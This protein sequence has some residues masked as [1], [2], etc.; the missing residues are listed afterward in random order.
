MNGTRLLIC[1][2]LLFGINVL[3]SDVQKST[4]KEALEFTLEDQYARSWSWSDHWKGKPTV[5]VMSDWKGYSHVDNW[6][7][8]LTNRFKGR[9]QFLAIA[10]LSL[11]QE[12]PSFM[13]PSLQGTL[14]ERFR[15]AFQHSI[16]MDW[17]GITF[18]YY[19]IQEGL[20]NVLYIDAS[21]IVRLH[22]WGKGSDDHVAKFADYLE[23]RL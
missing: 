3:A 21:G 13:L 20:P 6:T 5:V 15:E 23:R 19:L 22:T 10:D 2:L 1:V 14:R 8:P 17:E 12:A 11:T 4:G 9:V 7:K 18:K 16:L